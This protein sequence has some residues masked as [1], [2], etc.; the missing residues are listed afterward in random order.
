MTNSDI[1]NPTKIHE[2]LHV[3]LFVQLM[4]Q[5]FLAHLTTRHWIEKNSSMDF[6][7]RESLPFQIICI[8]NKN[9]L[10]GKPPQTSSD[11]RA[12]TLT[13]WTR[14]LERQPRDIQ[15]RVQWEYN[16][17]KW[18]ERKKNKSAA[19]SQPSCVEYLI[20]V[21][22]VEQICCTALVAGTTTV[23]DEERVGCFSK[24]QGVVVL[25]F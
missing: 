15:W 5:L 7:S 20:N 23:L 17:G 25:N 10:D 22:G 1:W 16:E 3:G 18:K 11:M 8:R 14:G 12:C 21:A 13:V 2:H 4:Q 24:D 9:Q 19:L 6:G